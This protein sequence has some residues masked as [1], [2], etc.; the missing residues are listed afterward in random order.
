MPRVRDADI[1]RAAAAVAARDPEFLHASLAVCELIADPSL[2][3]PGRATSLDRLLDGNHQD[4]F[5]AALGRL[6][7][8]DDRYV[9]LIHALARGCD[10][11][12]YRL[13][14]SVIPGA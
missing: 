14:N 4:L 7:R 9:P 3:L 10:P 2:M 5:A 11:Q 1:D 13:R 12:F 6:A 8:L